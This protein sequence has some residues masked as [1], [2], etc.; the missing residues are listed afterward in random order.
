MRTPLVLGLLVAAAGTSFAFP[1][2]AQPMSPTCRP[3]PDGLGV[4]CDVVSALG[5]ADLANRVFIDDKTFANVPND[6]WARDA[7]ELEGAMTP[8]C[9]EGPKLLELLRAERG[10]R[11]TYQR[12]RRP[13]MMEA[14]TI[15]YGL[16]EMPWDGDSHRLR[17][18]SPNVFLTIESGRFDPDPATG[19][20]RL[21]VGTDIMDDVYYDT[22]EFTLLDNAMSL[23]GRARWDSPTEVRRLLI[24]AKLGNRIDEFGLKNTAKIDIR[25]DSSTAADLAGLDEAVRSG[26]HNWESSRESAKPVRE[27]YTRLA[28][29]GKLPDVGTHENVLLLE[30]KA[31]LRSVRSRYH[32]NEANLRDVQALYTRGGAEH[33][34]ALLAQIKTTRDAGAIPAAR[35]AEVAAFEAKLAGI[36]DRTLI[37]E[38]A[39]AALKK[40]D[41]A[42]D[43]TAA[44][45]ANL[46]PGSTGTPA[47]KADIAKRKAV[48]DA[49]NA[50][51][52]ETARELDDVRRV[53]TASE[54]QALENDVARFVGF[55]KSEK[56]A[57]LGRITTVDPFEKIYQTIAALPEAQRAARLDAYNAYAEAQKAAGNRDFRTYTKLD[58]GTFTALGPQIANEKLRVWS[59]QMEAAGTAANGLWFDQAREV[60]VP[61]SNRATGNFLIDTM[62]MTEMYSP[63]SW[64]SIPATERTAGSTLPAAKAFNTVLV[65]ELQ[66]ELGQEKDY[67][68]RLNELTGTIEKD[69]ASLFM[70]WATASNS[71]AT[72]DAAGYRALHDSLKKKTDA[73]LKAT[74]DAINALRTAEGSAIDPITAADLKALDKAILVQ[75]T[76]DRAIRKNRD[77][78]ENLAGAQFVF[79]QYRDQL[80]FLSN[81]KGE[82][83]LRRLRDAGGPA[84]M[85][86][87]DIE[88]SKGDRA[89]KILKDKGTAPTS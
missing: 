54:D 1:A 64:A 10:G 82:A 88:M 22:P 13:E 66:I 32:L 62:D 38:R 28:A 23:R 41:P 43:V 12:L 45:I 76:R 9:V 75:E 53:I 36:T 16:D 3:T 29:M 79:G 17:E 21:S 18:A 55:L 61:S 25:N 40:L 20:R 5:E 85:E 77:V 65:N 6:G 87:K 30:P 58:A 74:V 56:P 47:T 83:V 42:M 4:I 80:K 71:A 33:V 35:A 39:S 69:R 63:E 48:A 51:Y 60:Y 84:C 24:G 14:F 50:L 44:T 37:A 67:L 59:R 81:A 78:E 11:T 19:R 70:R 72:N 57:E 31:Y 46:M 34:A 15:G 49:V 26:F 86:W 8:T 2:S 27:L 7:V 73:E 89:L 52:H 68:D